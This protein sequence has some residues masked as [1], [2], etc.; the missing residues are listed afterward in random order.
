MYRVDF[1]AAAPAITTPAGEPHRRRRRAGHLQRQRVGRR[2]AA[3]PVAAQRRQHR[4]RHRAGLHDRVGRAS[5]T[6]A[7]AS[8][9]SSPTTLGSA[10]SAEAV[11][12]VTANQAPTGDDHRSRPPARS[13]AAGWSSPTPGRAP[14]P[15]TARCPRAPSPGRSTSTTTRTSHPFIAA[16]DGRDQRLVHDP[17][18]GR[19]VGQ[20]L[21]PHLPDG[22]RLRRPHPHDV[23]RDVLPRKVQL[24]LATNPAGPRSS[25]STDSR[26][27][28]P[29]PST[30]VVG[31]VRTI[32]AP[33]PQTSG[34]DD[35]DFVSW[36]DGGAASHTI[37]TPAANT[38]YTATY[39]VAT[40]GTGTGLAATYFDNADFTG[41]DRDADR[42]DRRLR[43][44]RPARRR[45]PS[46][47][48]RSAPAGPARCSRSSP[49]PTRS[50]RSSDDGVR[51]WV[52]GVLVVNNWTDHG[53]DREQRH[54][55]AH[56]PASATTSGWSSTRTR[57]TRPRG[58]CGAARRRR[59]RSC[60]P[61]ASSRRPLRRRRR[62]ASTS[63][64]VGAPVPAGY[65][66]DGGLVYARSRQR[67]DLRVERRQHGAD[68]RSELVDLAR[69]ALRHARLHAAAGQPR[70]GL[71]DRRAE[72]HLHACAS[73]PAIPATST[74]STG[75]TVEGVLDRER[76]VDQRDA[77]GRGH[78]HRHRH[79]RPADDPQRRRA[80]A[81]TRSA[82]W[83]SRRSDV[84]RTSRTVPW[85]P[86]LLFNSAWVES[87]SSSSC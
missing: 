47:P 59:R 49:R 46:P 53:T 3:L 19:D 26:S 36:S 60:R 65:L 73:S 78:G 67:P 43:L 28:R 24:T 33:T 18:H 51:L 52:N 12:T 56:R 16:D 15:R 84:L 30:A 70:R 82:S 41:T 35:Y 13:T 66:K 79:R 55:R 34:G 22:P 21:V 44:G 45:R 32:G 68:A 42:S 57:A 81:T 11:L 4:R 69:S 7:R 63:S 71:G 85:H 23:Q 76:H 37:S 2:A 10:T 20:R 48:T 62:S 58:C 64:R 61:R 27:P 8:A 6:T 31:I 1:G 50:T 87:F 86:P 54:D 5:R 77:L 38:T 39:R 17:D 72:R 25:G 40:G 14:I 9:R 29:L 75:S 83:R 80:R 74:A